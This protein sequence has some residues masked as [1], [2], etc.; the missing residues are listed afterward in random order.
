M[1]SNLT[2]FVI[3]CST[4]VL[5]TATLVYL[6]PGQSECSECNNLPCRKSRKSQWM[7]YMGPVVV[8]WWY[9]LRVWLMYEVIMKFH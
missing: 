3:E 2:L 5:L 1:A 4:L 6:W 8:S 7:P 9:G